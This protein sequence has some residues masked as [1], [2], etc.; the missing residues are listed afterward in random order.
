MKSEFTLRRPLP[1][2]TLQMWFQSAPTVHPLRCFSATTVTPSPSCLAPSAPLVAV[3]TKTTGPTPQIKG[4]VLFG[5]KNRLWTMSPIPF[6]LVFGPVTLPWWMMGR[7]VREIRFQSLLR[8][9]GIT[10]CTF[11]VIRQP[12]PVPMPKSKFGWMGKL[13]NE[14][15]GL[16]SF[17]ARSE[18]PAAPSAGGPCCCS[19]GSSGGG[20]DDLTLLLVAS[21][22]AAPG[23]LLPATSGGTFATLEPPVCSAV[24]LSLVSDVASSAL[25][26]AGVA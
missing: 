26:A 25:S 23:L 19:S 20:G 1:P 6:W 13:I 5:E 4:S 24:V 11:V 12:L 18:A 9:M 17:F 21:L 8:A 14:A 2:A 15:T 7:M 10:G 3:G 22:A 16:A